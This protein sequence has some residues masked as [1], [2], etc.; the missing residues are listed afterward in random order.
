[1]E[2]LVYYHIACYGGDYDIIKLILDKGAD[3]NA[4]NKH[5]NTALHIAIAY[6]SNIKVIM[7]LLDRGAD[8]NASDK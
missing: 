8:V 5:E 6:S 4:S 2:A 7:A 1:M 3:V